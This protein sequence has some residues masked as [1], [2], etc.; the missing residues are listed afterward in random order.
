ML[1]WQQEEAGVYT[2]L[3]MDE[4]RVHIQG[5][6]IGVQVQNW[7]FYLSDICQLFFTIHTL[8]PIAKLTLFSIAFT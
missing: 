5:L 7:P 6:S 4:G 8:N 1:F 3:L 2:Q